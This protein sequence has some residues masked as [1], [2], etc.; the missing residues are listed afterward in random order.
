MSESVRSALGR[1][2]ERLAA[3][4]CDTPGVDAELLLAH[5]MGTTRSGVA[6]DGRRLLADAEKTRLSA[7]VERRAGREPLAYVLGEWGFR[8]L[9]LDVDSRVLVPRPETEIVVERCLSLITGLDAPRVLDVGTGSGAIALALTDEHP[10]ARVTGIDVSRDALAVAGGNSVKTGVSVEL[11]E[12]DLFGGLPE[13]PWALVVSNPP[14]VRIGDVDTL[15]R[16]ARD[17]EPRTALVAEGATDAIVRGAL[18]VLEPRGAL[19]LEVAD[20]DAGRVAGL[21]GELG[22]RDIVVTVDLAGRDRVVEG[23]KP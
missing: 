4:G 2:E 14:Y 15:P 13:G 1:V 21:L 20:G 22:Y 12:W 5:V 9:V 11:A 23:V 7:L 18:P 3:A 10:G 19:V 17:W 6:A 16:E 8:R